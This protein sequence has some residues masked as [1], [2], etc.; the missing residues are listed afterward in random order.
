MVLQELFGIGFCGGAICFLIFLPF[1]IRFLVAYYIYEDAKKRGEEEMLW[2]IVGLVAGIIGLIIWLI[3]RPD[4]REVRM[5]DQ[6]W[7]GTQYDQRAI[8]PQDR[9]VGKPCP[10]CDSP[11]RWI[12][13]HNRW[14]CDSCREYK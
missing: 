3:V 7:Q 9:Q 14:F 2:L 8:P 13:E 10:D 4:R 6:R 12:T 1:L 5:N 11:M